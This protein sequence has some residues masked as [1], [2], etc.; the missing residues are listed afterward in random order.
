MFK[1]PCG[2]DVLMYL[3]AGGGVM[4]GRACGASMPDA[5]ATR[6]SLFVRAAPPIR[7]ATLDG[8]TSW[9]PNAQVT[10]GAVLGRAGRLV[11]V[12]SAADRRRAGPLL[13]G[14][15]SLFACSDWFSTT[16]AARLRDD[17]VMRVA[18]RQAGWR[19]LPAGKPQPRRRPGAPGPRRRR[20]GVGRRAR[21]SARARGWAGRATSD[22][23]ST[24][25]ARGRWP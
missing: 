10:R 13:R 9:A 7:S 20:D 1:V 25:R 16:G 24:G 19:S 4:P 11:G 3:P 12:G 14:A 22:N 21:G 23:G 2:H 15:R 17:L 5:D 8:C 6:K 18:P